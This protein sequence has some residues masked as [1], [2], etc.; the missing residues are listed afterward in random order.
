MYFIVLFSVLSLREISSVGVPAL[1]G[2]CPGPWLLGKS[3]PSG[4]SFMTAGTQ[5]RITLPPIVPARA[6]GLTEGALSP[7]RLG[8]GGAAPEQGFPSTRT[9]GI[10]TPGLVPITAPGPR[11]QQRPPG[12]PSTAPGALH[13]GLPS[14]SIP[15]WQ[16]LLGSCSRQLPSGW[17]HPGALVPAPAPQ[18]RPKGRGFRLPLQGRV[19]QVGGPE[20]G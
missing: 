16:L 2:G 4:L 6:S 20:G 8:E 14:L 19:Q 5:T 15:K 12:T 11:G 18:G 3:T 10:E 13:P 1:L 7:P 9:S 17:H